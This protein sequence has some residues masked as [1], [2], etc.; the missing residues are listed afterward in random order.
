MPVQVPDWNQA[1]RDPTL[2]LMVDIGS[3]IISTLKTPFF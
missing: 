1:F 3:G 2:P